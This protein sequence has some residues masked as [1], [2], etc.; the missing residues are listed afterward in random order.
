VVFTRYLDCPL[1][2]VGQTGR[3]SADR[4]KGHIQA[5]RKNNGNSG[6]SNHILNTRHTYATITVKM[7]IIKREEKESI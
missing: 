1:N 2:Y 7:D 6:Y 3:T 5:I 4:Y